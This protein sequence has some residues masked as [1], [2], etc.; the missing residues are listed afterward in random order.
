M[1]LCA[2]L[3]LV[4]KGVRWRVGN[5]QNI[6]VWTDSWIPRD[7]CL[8]PVTPNFQQLNNLR[9]A[10]LLFDT[11]GWNVELIQDL[12]W[13]ED[14]AYI[15]GIPL[16]TESGVDT[17]IWHYCKHGHYFVRSAYF[18]ARDMKHVVRCNLSGS[19]S[20]NSFNWNWIWQLKLPNKIKVFFWRVIKHPLPV[21]CACRNVVLILICLALFVKLVMRLFY[22]C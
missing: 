9:V 16:P 12:F 3:P 18:L 13:E 21:N 6:Q 2:A 20:S 8:T 17:R 7:G 22:I 1:Q 10:D 11:G 14:S 19:S 4:R 5:G 15:L